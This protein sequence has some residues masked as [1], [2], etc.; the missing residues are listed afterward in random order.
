MATQ[1]QLRRGN[2]SQI[3]A[4]TG[5]IAELTVDIEKNTV[6]VHNG[7]TL[8][9]FPLA[10]ES[11]AQ[12]AFNAANT[13]GGAGVDTYARN[14]ANAAFEAANSGSSSVFS[15][16]SY[17][18]A[19]AAF[20]LANNSLS[21]NTGGIVAGAITATNLV[22]NSFIQFGDGSR[23]YTANAGTGGGGGGNVQDYFPTDTNWGYLNSSFSSF[24]EN[25]SLQ[26]DC[27]DDPI[28]PRGYFLQKDFGYLT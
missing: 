8:G 17:N 15:Q 16:S 14:H 1:V 5:A 22:S 6:V 12:A 2:T 13:G 19:N 23:Q 27:K 18:H 25:L 26:Y 9:G 11:F 10:L 21:I 24:G 3:N 7:S 4:F 28:T 20:N